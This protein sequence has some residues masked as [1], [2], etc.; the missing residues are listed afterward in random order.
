MKPSQRYAG[1]YREQTELG[2]AKFS[3]LGAA[4]PSDKSPFI[5]V[6]SNP[7]RGPSG[8]HSH[9]AGF[10]GNALSKAGMVDLTPCSQK[11]H[12]LPYINYFKEY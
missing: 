8:D 12:G 5:D 11:A 7:L 6:K 4:A 1:I 3:F 9:P 10:A 2:I